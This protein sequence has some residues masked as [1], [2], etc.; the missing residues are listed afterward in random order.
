MLS[1]LETDFVRRDPA[2]PGLGI[3]LDPGALVENLQ[4]SLS[5]TDL[6][7]ARITYI[8]YKRGIVCLVGYK[9]SAGGTDV[10]MYAKA[11]GAD[12]SVKLEKAREQPGLPG[13]LGTGRIPLDDDQ[14]V[15]SVFPND[16]K[17]K[18]LPILMDVEARR[19]L[20][21]RILARHG[22]FPDGRLEGLAYKPER[23]Y[24]ARLLTGAGPR[25]LLKFYTQPG[26]EDV[27]QRHC[28]PFEERPP[29]RLSAWIGK[30]SRRAVMAFEWLPGA[31]LSEAIRDPDFD[32]RALVTVGAA[33]AQLHAQSHAGLPHVTHRIQANA[34]V[35]EASVIGVICPHLAPEAAAASR[36]IASHLIERPPVFSLI[37]ADLHPRQVLLSDDSAAILD[38]DRTVYADPMTDL[39]LF[40]SYLERDVIRGNLTAARVERLMQALIEGYTSITHQPVAE[41]EIRLYT[42][43]E[44]V[45][46]A[47]RFFRDWERDW[48][49]R[50]ESSLRRAEALL[51]QTSASKPAM[52][53]R[54]S[55]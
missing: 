14:I 24:V 8:K 15:V 42:A 9:L 28:E 49:E 3:V 11:F 38:L 46:L 39:G 47:P 37:H 6:G 31:L 51:T 7:P 1:P 52:S 45:R 50:I 21:G 23:R 5:R 55:R 48:P 10:D 25:A 36:R 33:I 22:G 29:L 53:G 4:R 16:G 41:D 12:A 30:S 2:L 13:A 43:A 26:Y 35:S 40:A 19:H 17:V 34:L 44:L 18:A 32:D 27:A 20:L 54:A